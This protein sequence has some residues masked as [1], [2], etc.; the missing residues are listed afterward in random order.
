MT[1]PANF[2]A[3]IQSKALSVARW[4][5]IEGIPY[6]YGTFT[7]TQAFFAARASKDQ[8]LGVKGF[9]KAH[10]APKNVDQNIDTLDGGALTRGTAEFKIVDKDDDVVKWAG[11]GYTTNRLFLSQEL[12]YDD[13]VVSFLGNASGYAAGQYIY[14]GSETIKI[15]VIA[16]QTFQG[17]LRG[18]FRSKPQSF[19]KGSPIGSRPYTMAMR[20]IWYHQ[21]ATQ[22]GGTVVEQD[23]AIR[24]SGALKDLRLDDGDPNTFILQAASIDFELDRPC[25]RN[26]RSFKMVGL[27]IADGEG[28]DGTAQVRGW[29]GGTG[30][31][32]YDLPLSLKLADGIFQQYILLKIDDEIFL[33]NIVEASALSRRLDLNA[34]ALFGTEAK[35]HKDGAIVNEIIPVFASASPSATTTVGGDTVTAIRQAS[36]FRSEPTDS[37]PY[38]A[39][40]PLMIILQV[41]LSTG[42]GIYTGAALIGGTNWSGNTADRNYDVLP[43]DWGMGIDYTRVDIQAWEAAAAEEPQLRFGGFVSG[44]PLNFVNFM[45]DMLKFAGYYFF[46]TLGDKISVRRLRPPFP[47]VTSKVLNNSVRIHRTSPSWGANWSATIREVIFKFGYDLLLKDHKRI[48]IFILNEADVYSKGLARTITLETEFLYPG[49]SNIRGEPPFAPFDVDQWLITRKDFYRVRYARPPPI[50]RERADLSFMDVNIGDLVIVDATNLPST[51]TG[52]RGLSQ[53]IGEIILKRIEEQSKTVFFSILMTGYALGRYR[54]I[55][56]SLVTNS[57]AGAPALALTIWNLEL[58]AFSKAVGAHGS[59]QTDLKVEDYAGTL[60][61]TFGLENFKVRLWRSDFSSYV[62][63]LVTID[64]ATMR[65]GA[66]MEDFSNLPAWVLTDTT[67]IFTHRPQNVARLINV[68]D[69]LP[70]TS[71]Y[72]YAASS[73][74]S[75]VSLDEPHRYF[76]T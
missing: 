59:A 8:F 17:C 25:F 12:S 1:V 56:P 2:L 24:F 51:V 11:I 38:P 14:I 65:V 21:T 9:L 39:D 28:R 43:G 72:A 29:P 22:S 64:E 19:G 52:A 31:T 67:V 27:S 32:L 58:N 40:H 45:R 3:A 57:F 16:G 63:C 46:S 62:D 49:G 35:P 13:S 73:A 37:S 71:L 54:F 42:T 23:K 68:G 7:A 26:I 34:R 36:K 15:G 33:G 69:A 60:Q 6:A 55:A 44:E 61:Y 47:D 75:F 50:I 4:I 66:F 76:P 70:S 30:A 10:D 41:M 18:Q 5:E 48:D 53:E 74:D 20:K